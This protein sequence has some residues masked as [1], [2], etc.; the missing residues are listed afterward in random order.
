[1]LG[2][3]T[4]RRG[5]Y[6]SAWRVFHDECSNSTLI[7]ILPSCRCSCTVWIQTIWRLCDVF[8]EL[9]ITIKLGDRYL[10]CLTIGSQALLILHLQ[11]FAVVRAPTLND[12]S[13]TQSVM[14]FSSSPVLLLVS[15]NQ[16][17]SIFP[18]QRMRIRACS[19]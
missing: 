4:H 9:G 17:H 13:M 12:R 3:C 14:C 10:S 16:R 6:G 19:Y 18:F 1:M 8:T 5:D 11:L 2:W 7:S 15:P